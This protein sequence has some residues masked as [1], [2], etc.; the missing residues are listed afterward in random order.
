LGGRRG[1]LIPVEERA[2]A[3]SLIIEAVEAGA[4]VRPACEVLQISVRTYQ[5][6]KKNTAMGDQRYA[7][8]RHIARKLS[9]DEREQVVRIC[10]SPEYQDASPYA[11]YAD[12]LDKG[13][14]VASVSTMY[15]ILRERGLL[16]HRGESRPG[17][18][19][20]KP[21]ELKAT[22]PNQVWSWDITFLPTL[23]NG[24]FLYGYVLMDVWSRKIVG[25]EVHTEES[26]EHARE[27]FRRVAASQ[28]VRGVHLHS[29]NGNPMK[30]TTI[31]VLFFALGILPSYSRPRVSNDNPFSESL[32]K[33]LKYRPGY[34]KRFRDTDQ[35]R[36]WFANFV[37]WYNTEHRHS[38]IGYITPEDRHQGRTPQIMAHRNETLAAARAKYPERWPNGQMHWNEYPVVYLN[39]EPTTRQSLMHKTA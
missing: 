34:P 7:A 25:W 14:Y 17:T 35:A 4:R 13:I 11:I 2:L 16:H 27:F 31:L 33:T 36:R 10:C 12:L 22:G 21:A 6:W 30:G 8:T 24:I 5:R 26:E 28:N 29:D 37:H 19:H 15:R 23:V 32:F 1:R 38:G 20:A 18:R 39:P 9:D 3:V